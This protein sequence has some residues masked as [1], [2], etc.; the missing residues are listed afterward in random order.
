LGGAAN[1]GTFAVGAE[2]ALTAELGVH[3]ADAVD[4]V[5]GLV[6]PRDLGLELLVVHGTR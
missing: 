2:H 4:A 5:V 6:H 1:H 3:L